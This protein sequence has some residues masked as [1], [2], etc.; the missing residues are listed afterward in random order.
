MSYD[1]PGG[2]FYASSAG[3]WGVENVV[4]SS[5]AGT[6]SS[7]G[8]DANGKAFISYYD[9]GD[10][11]QIRLKYATTA[12]LASDPW[13]FTATPGSKKFSLHWNQPNSTGDYPRIGYTVKVYNQDPNIGVNLQPIISIGIPEANTSHVVTGLYNGAEYWVQ[14]MANSRAGEGAS[15]PLLYVVPGDPPTAPTSFMAAAEHNNIT[16]L[17]YPPLYSN[18]SAVTNYSILW[19]LST[20]TMTN[21]VVLGDELTFV[22]H[23]L[24]LGQYYYYKVRARNGYGWGPYTQVVGA[25]ALGYPPQTPTGLV[26]IGEDSQIVLTWNAP[27]MGYLNP[28]ESYL[29][30]K[31]VYDDQAPSY[32][33]ATVAN[34]TLTYTDTQ[35]SSGNNYYYAVVAKNQYGQS[36]QSDVATAIPLGQP[37]Y[38]HFEGDWLCIA[39]ALVIG[40]AAAGLITIYW[41]RSRGHG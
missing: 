4:A 13:S 21:E 41:R 2:L 26:A 30:Y 25:Q 37:N 23:D 5:G 34:G 3:G 22:H 20:T 10:S 15:S 16:L 8:I 38:N 24:L 27:P 36:P 29:V 33:I 32:V 28:V 39:S 6:G 12:T 35:V 1:Q 11:V 19:G 17:W 9:I 18:S 7:I 40:L 14:V 31:T